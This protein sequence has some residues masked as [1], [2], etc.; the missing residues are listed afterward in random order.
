MTEIAQRL[1]ENVEQHVRVCD[2]ETEQ[3]CQIRLMIDVAQHTKQCCVVR[4]KD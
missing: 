3:A 4:V 2:V 1:L